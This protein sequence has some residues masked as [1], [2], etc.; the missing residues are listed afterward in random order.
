MTGLH[1]EVWSYGEAA[2]PIPRDY[3]HVGE[4]QHVRDAAD[5]GAEVAL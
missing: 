1:N 2:Y 5:A 3:L 4:R